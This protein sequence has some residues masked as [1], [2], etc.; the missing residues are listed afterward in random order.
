MREDPLARR[1]IAALIDLAAFI[2]LTA[3]VFHFF[4]REVHRE[5]YT[6]HYI[7]GFPI[8]FLTAIWVFY[9]P[10]TESCFG[11]TLGKFICGISVVSTRGTDLAFWQTLLRRLLDPLE[12]WF[13]FGLIGF[14]VAAVAEDGR[15]LGDKLADTRVIRDQA[16]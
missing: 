5:G 12:I 9:Y 8:I 15:R 11:K 2:G 10:F 13:A 3:L 4:G 6:F 7:S 14:V 1:A 16:G